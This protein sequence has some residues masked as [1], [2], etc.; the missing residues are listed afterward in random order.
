MIRFPRCYYFE[1]YVGD[2]TLLVPTLNCHLIYT[3]FPRCCSTFDLIDLRYG[4]LI[5]V[6]VCPTSCC[7]SSLFPVGG[8]PLHLPTLSTIVVTWCSRW[9]T[10]TIHSTTDVTG[11]YRFTFLRSTYVYS[12]IPHTPTSTPYYLRISD[13]CYLLLLR[14][15]DDLILPRIPYAPLRFGCSYHTRFTT[16]TRSGRFGAFDSLYVTI[17]H[18]THTRSTFYTTRVTTTPRTLRFVHHTTHGP[19][20][21]TTSPLSLTISHGVVPFRCLPLLLHVYATDCDIVVVPVVTLLPRWCCYSFTATFYVTLVRYT[22]DY[23]LFD[24][25]LPFHVPFDLLDFAFVHTLRL[26]TSLRCCLFDFHDVRPTFPFPTISRVR[27][28]SR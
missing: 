4:N 3:T 28:R 17:V 15:D 7:S 13:I 2:V 26:P 10:V 23:D 24:L 27:L 8:L 11:R 6:V 21:W 19:G 5:H 9:A 16:F 18:S 25:I 1:F 12:V 14:F 20:L 22:P